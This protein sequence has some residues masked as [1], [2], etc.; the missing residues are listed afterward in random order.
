MSIDLG[1]FKH[2]YQIQVRS[3][4]VDAQRIVHNSVYLKY[5]EIG[6]IEY[7]KTFGYKLNPDGTFNDGLKFF[8]VHNSLDY[9]SPAIVDDVLNIYTRV[10]W[11]KNS[12]F[13]FE[14][15]IENEKTKKI[16]CE[17]KGILVNVDGKMNEPV[18]LDKKFLDE[19]LQFEEQIKVIRE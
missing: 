18:K 14:Q 9:R 11:V 1:K 13:C 19:L 3:F 16:V 2:K 7:R 10:S 6:R 4:E 5:L 15:V 12:S 8:V 17:G